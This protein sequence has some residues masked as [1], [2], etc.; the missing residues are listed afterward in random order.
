MTMSSPVNAAR[1]CAQNVTPDVAVS[2]MRCRPRFWHSRCREA[3][4]TSACWADR[5]SAGVGRTRYNRAHI[6]QIG[7]ASEEDCWRP[8]TAASALAQVRLAGH[9]GDGEAHLEPPLLEGVHE[10]RDDASCATMQPW[11]RPDEVENQT[12]SSGS[13]RGAWPSR[14]QSGPA[15]WPTRQH[16]HEPPAVE[17]EH[18]NPDEDE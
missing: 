9:L 2:A 15:A 10:L 11:G 13:P 1:Q 12:R 5:T 4:A 6:P 8:T 3:R 17:V 7:I 18:W 16:V 14:R